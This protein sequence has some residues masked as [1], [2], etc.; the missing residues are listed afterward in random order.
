MDAKKFSINYLYFG[1]LFVVLMLLASSSIFIKEDL[2]GSR[3]FFFFHALG[4]IIL[5]VSFLIF[6]ASLVRKYLGKFCF[7]VFIGG[8]FFAFVLHIFDYLLDRIL[9]L[10]ILEAFRI[11]VLYENLD[12]FLYLLDASGIPIW[13]WVILICCLLSI[14]FLGMLIYKLLDKIVQKNPLPFRHTVFLQMFLCVPFALFFFDFSASK[15]IH[16]DAYTAFIKSLPWKFT[17]LH[18]RNVIIPIKTIHEPR[19][20]REIASEIKKDQTILL[21]KPNIYLLVIESLREDFIT[22][23]IAPNLYRFKNTY[24]HYQTALSNGNGS[25]ISWFSIFHSQFP[26][27]WYHM[28]KQ[29]KMGSSALNLLK[30]WGYQIR[31][32][33]S[34]QLGYYG[35]D[36]LLFGRDLH[37]LDQVKN[38]HHIPPLQAADTDAAAIA[39]LQKDIADDPS[40]Q[41]GQVFILFLDCTHFDWKIWP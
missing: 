21:Q 6:G 26:F 36:E 25:H 35:M 17:F 7:F 23:E 14:P 31:L 12:N 4:Q 29:W 27:H 8:T 13:A 19:S 40:L 1:F 28:Q 3:L 32:Y 20:E 41:Q 9:D 2:N 37:L 33:S 5:E 22:K 24:S 15:M 10:S 34:A 16:P 18:P 30:K 11:F 38:F 39:A